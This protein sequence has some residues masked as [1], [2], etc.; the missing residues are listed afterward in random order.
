LIDLFNYNLSLLQS[1]VFIRV[2]TVNVISSLL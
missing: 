2:F 1:Q